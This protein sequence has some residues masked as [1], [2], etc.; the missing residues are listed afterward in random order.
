MAAEALACFSESAG[1]GP[2]S[3][4]GF[5]VYLD[6]PL[7]LDILGVNSEYEEYGKELLELIKVS[8]ASPVVFDDAVAEAESVVSARLAVARSGQNQTTSADR[9]R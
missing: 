4:E 3:L 6:S 1:D 7:L 8:K 2:E 5:S 9:C